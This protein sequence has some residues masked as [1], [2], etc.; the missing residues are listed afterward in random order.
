MLLL[1]LRTAKFEVRSQH[2]AHGGGSENLALLAT[3]TGVL[4]GLA[5]LA[6]R[7]ALPLKLKALEAAMQTYCQPLS[8]RKYS[9]LYA[10]GTCLCRTRCAAR[11]T[12]L[13]S[14]MASPPESLI[15]A[16]SN[17]QNAAARC[18]HTAHALPLPIRGGGGV[19]AAKPPAGT[20]A[21]R[22]ISGRFPAVCILGITLTLYVPAH[23]KLFALF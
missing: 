13:T 2:D 10:C 22:C 20:A 3:A 6:H 16:H 19:L 7:A 12:L 5:A 23:Q 15:I 8:L 9:A 21:A 14:C 1:L 17:W 11:M 4:K 18:A